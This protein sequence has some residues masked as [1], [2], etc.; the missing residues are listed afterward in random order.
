MRGLCSRASQI[1]AASAASFSPRLPAI[2]SGVANFDAIQRPVCPSR[3]HQIGLAGLIDAMPAI[4][5]SC[6]GIVNDANDWAVET[7]GNPRYPLE[8]FQRVGTVSIETM[9]IVRALP[10]LKL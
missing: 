7:M 6:S 3:A 4:E 5:D 8:L 1:A 10:T 2:R 9:K